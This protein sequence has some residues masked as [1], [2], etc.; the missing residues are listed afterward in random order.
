MGSPTGARG[1]PFGDGIRPWSRCYITHDACAARPAPRF[2]R[3]CRSCTQ[4]AERQTAPSSIDLDTRGLTS[5]S[6]RERAE[7]CHGRDQASSPGPALEVYSP[8]RRLPSTLRGP[9]RPAVVLALGPHWLHAR[10]SPRPRPRPGPVSAVWPRPAPFRALAR[11]AS[12]PA[13]PSLPWCPRP[14]SFRE[15]R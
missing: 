9:R 14:P 8:H 6:A 13:S 2:S 15:P 1:Q 4:R 11:P 3:P 10:P 7:P 5:L 12:A